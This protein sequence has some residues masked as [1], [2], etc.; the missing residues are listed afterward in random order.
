[1]RHE[2]DRISAKA[3]TQDKTV[4][5]GPRVSDIVELLLANRLEK[6]FC[7]LVTPSTPKYH[8]PLLERCFRNTPLEKSV[9]YV[10][11]AV[12]LSVFPLW[13]RRAVRKLKELTDSGTAVE[14][15]RF[16]YGGSYRDGMLDYFTFR[17]GQPR[18][19]AALCLASLFQYIEGPILD[20]ACGVG[21]LTHYLTNGC[22]NREVVGIDRN[23]LQLV[24]AKTYVAP[25]AAY[26]CCEADRSLPFSTDSFAGILCSDAFHYFQHRIVCVREMERLAKSDGLMLITRFGNSLVEP[27]EGYELTPEG[28][29]SLFCNRPTVLTCEDSLLARY[30]QKHGPKLDTEP[31]ADHLKAQKWLSAVTSTRTDLFHDDGALESWPHAVGRLKINPL[32]VEE[33]TDSS[34]ER[35]FRFRFPSR[36]YEIEDSNYRQ[37]A[38][39]LVRLPAKV[40]DQ[41]EAG[42]RTNE[43]EKL[44]AQCFLIGMPDRYL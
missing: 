32:Y 35:V 1:M 9:R 23:F 17:F 40:F 43:I 27:R 25:A 33:E 37:Y 6:A 2:R 30:L 13:R 39:D 10:E 14:A 42:E 36:W 34:E 24:I 5:F 44:V 38:P 41:I 4:F 18:H 19:L 3:Q 12:G 31:S 8:L 15:L 7:S 11:A 22:G 29:G 20:I 26:V 21:H 28:Y 16:Y